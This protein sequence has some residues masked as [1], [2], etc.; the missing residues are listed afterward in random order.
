MVVGETV[1]MTVLMTV[2]VEETTSAYKKPDIG[3]KLIC[4]TQ[5][6]HSSTNH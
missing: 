2:L 6:H 3:Y 5:L 4:I 1:L